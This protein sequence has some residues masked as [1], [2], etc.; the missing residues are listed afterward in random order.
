MVVSSPN[1]HTFEKRLFA[2]DKNR[3][4]KLGCQVLET[5]WYCLW[6]HRSTA[7][8][9]FGELVGGRQGTASLINWSSCSCSWQHTRGRSFLEIVKYLWSTIRKLVLWSIGPCGWL[10][11]V[12]RPVSSVFLEGGRLA[13]NAKTP[14]HWGFADYC[15]RFLPR[16]D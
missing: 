1:I 15:G 7:R 16:K 10:H 5:E 8:F 3:F 6:Y 14:P 11:V 9:V 4:Q 2:V 12:E 13:G